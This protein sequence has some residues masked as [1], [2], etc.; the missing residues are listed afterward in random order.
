VQTSLDCVPC[1]LRQTLD[2]MRQVTDDRA[3]HE[4]VLRRVLLAAGEM[5]LQRPP[6]AMGQ[7]IHRMIR[8]ATGS[9]DPYR[10]VKG[11]LNELALRMFPDLRRRVA[12]APDALNTAV[13][14]AAAGNVID[15][16]VKSGIDRSEIAGA[17]ES[18]LE[19]PL[20]GAAVERLRRAAREAKSILYIGD[21]AGEIVLDRLLVEQLGP[22][23][24]TFAVRGAPTIND[25]TAGDAAASGMADL[26]EIVD[27]GSDAPGTILE[28]CSE[29]FRRR[30][31]RAHLVV[32]KGQ[33]NYET[34]SEAKR[35]VFFLLKAKCPVIAADIGCPVGSLVLSERRVVGAGPAEGGGGG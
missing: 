18:S 14:L 12:E 13:R 19:A 3:E 32:A 2:A 15:L 26:V 21:N 33:G 8:E 5:D 27:S 30:F 9:A 34:L 35:P 11:Q 16:G 28:D 23:R 7:V 17:I 31:A 1:F 25:A 10:G 22:D 6:P 24:V 29:D 4:R 20:D